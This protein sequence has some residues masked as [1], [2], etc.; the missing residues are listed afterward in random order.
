[1]NTGNSDCNEIEFAPVK[2]KD[3]QRLCVHDRRRGRRP[4]A[5]SPARG[6][7]HR[8]LRCGR[9]VEA[10]RRLTVCVCYTCNRF[11]RGNVE[12][13]ATNRARSP[14]LKSSSSID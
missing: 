9:P 4:P 8:S 3:F 14:F 1:M 10:P 11:S 12:E 13:D 6:E 7:F 5:V 2:V